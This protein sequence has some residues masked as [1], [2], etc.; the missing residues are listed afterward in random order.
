MARIAGVNVPKD[1]RFVIALTYI[2]GIGLS[3]SKSICS[4]LRLDEKKR[5]SQL[6]DAELDATRLHIEKMGIILEGDL[7]R[8]VSSV[9]SL[10][11]LFVFTF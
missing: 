6:T 10:L 5:T 1:K 11:N 2:Y 9:K 3:T 7:R 8:K 4:S